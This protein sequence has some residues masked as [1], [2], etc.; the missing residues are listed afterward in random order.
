MEGAALRLA[1]QDVAVVAVVARVR[2]GGA[3][4]AVEVLRRAQPAY[5]GGASQIVA[6]SHTVSIQNAL[7]CAPVRVGRV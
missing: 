5:V 7:I 2:L 3:I 4:R 1:A 6:A